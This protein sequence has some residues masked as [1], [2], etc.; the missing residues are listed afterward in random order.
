MTNAELV[1]LIQSGDRDKL[2]DLWEQVERFVAMQAGKQILTLKGI[3]GVEYEDLYQSGY[4]ALVAAADSYDPSSRRSF[5]S[6]LVPHLKKAFAAAGGYRSR[7]QGLD[8][9][10]FAGSLDLHVEDD[11]DSTIGDL[12]ADP[13]ADTAFQAAEDRIWAEQLHA[14]LDSALNKLPDNQA[15]A[16][17]RRFYQKQGPREIAAAKGV[18]WWT[19]QTWQKQ[20]LRALCR[21]QELR[22]FL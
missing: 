4:I 14:A 15:E 22:R 7:K 6:W 12:I 10:H 11:L 8:P 9:L 13:N 2:P 17:R 1:T 3:G 18:P 5:I 16:L 19:V 21:R 20:G